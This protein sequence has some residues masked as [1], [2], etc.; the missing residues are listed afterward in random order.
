[1]EVIFEISTFE[2]MDMRLIDSGGILLSILFFNK[3]I[4]SP[5]HSFSIDGDIFLEFSLLLGYNK[6]I[7]NISIIQK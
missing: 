6:N 5:N 7:R 3:F 1:M 4:Q 2:I